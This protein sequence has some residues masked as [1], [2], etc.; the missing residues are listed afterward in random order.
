MNFAALRRP[1]FGKKVGTLATP[2]GGN[3]LNFSLHAR[4]AQSGLTCNGDISVCHHPR[5]AYPVD[6]HVYVLSL[7]KLRDPG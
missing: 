4:L 2:V 3:S 7:A 1:V 6:P 5:H